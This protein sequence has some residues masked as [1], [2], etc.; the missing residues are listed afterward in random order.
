MCDVDRAGAVRS[1]PMGLYSGPMGLLL[2]SR[3]ACSLGLIA[4]LWSGPMGLSFDGLGWAD[5]L[6]FWADG[7]AWSGPMG[8]RSVMG[9]WFEPPGLW[10][11]Y[12]GV[13]L[14]AVVAVVG[15]NC[16]WLKFV[17]VVGSNCRGCCGWL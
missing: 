13:A 1:G 14:I 5:G 10:P 7:L 6:V 11:G 12:G 2:W 17:A 16:R 9:L 4:L 8:L 3:W 15:S